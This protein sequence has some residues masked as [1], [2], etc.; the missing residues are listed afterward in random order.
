MRNP[1]ATGGDVNVATIALPCMTTVKIEA[2]GIA[3]SRI[4]SK[5]DN[6]PAFELSFAGCEADVP[7]C[8]SE[9]T[10]RRGVRNTRRVVCIDRGELD[11]AAHRR[12]VGARGAG[13]DTNGAARVVASCAAGDGDVPAIAVGTA[14]IDAVAHTVSSGDLHLT[15]MTAIVRLRRVLEGAASHDREVSALR[16]G[17]GGIA[18]GHEHLRTVVFVVGAR[19]DRNVPAGAAVR[20]AIARVH[21]VGHAC[22]DHDSSCGARA[23]TVASAHFDIAAVR[24]LRSGSGKHLNRATKVLSD[25]RSSEEHVARY[26]AC[27]DANVA[28]VLSAAPRVDGDV[29]ARA[30]VV[31]VDGISRTHFDRATKKHILRL[32]VINSRAGVHDDVAAEGVRATNL[33]GVAPSDAV[34]GI[35]EGVAG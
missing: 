23:T 34:F 2:A 13:V 21:R 3:V 25:V 14:G 20:L 16:I 1:S 19:A 5:H 27:I 7:S 29:P 18:S 11:V 15:A 17:Q 4:T 35:H 12:S 9:R 33:K 8:A 24:K 10:D 6:V 30:E 28:A 31:I 22:A 26:M 32:D